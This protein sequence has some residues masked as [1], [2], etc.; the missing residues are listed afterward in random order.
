MDH[1]Y[2]TVYASCLI[3]LTAALCIVLGLTAWLMWTKCLTAVAT[4]RAVAAARGK[5]HANATAITRTAAANSDDE[6][7]GAW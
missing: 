5:L 2:F 6:I 4:R 1:P 7:G 3:V